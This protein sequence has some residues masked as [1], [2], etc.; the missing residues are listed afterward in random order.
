[1]PSRPDARP[2]QAGSISKERFD[3]PL[4]WDSSH[5]FL[6]YAITTLMMTSLAVFVLTA[7][8]MP[9]QPARVV[10]GL[11]MALM[12]ATALFLLL[13]GKVETSV[14]V[15]VYGTWTL[16]TAILTFTGGLR[17]PLA[18]GYPLITLLSGWLLGARTARSIGFMTLAAIACLTLADTL[19]ILPHP[20]T[21][22][23]I[24][25][26]LHAITNGFAI[27]LIFYLLR[28][29]QNR[30]ADA[31]KLSSDLGRLA[32]KVQAH[33]LDLNRA[34][35][36]AHVGS[37]VYEIATDITHSSAEACRIFGIAEGAT[38]SRASYL[39]H[40]H[41]DD[42][43]AIETAW[44]AALAGEPL[45]QEHRIKTGDGMRWIR[46]R[47]ELER[48]PDGTPLRFVGTT[49]DTTDVRKIESELR[50]AA[51]AFESQ[52]GMIV[53]NHEN[54]I[55]RVNQAF[56][57]I[58]GYSREDAVGRHHRPRRSG[59]HDNAFYAAIAE[60]VKQTGQ[61]TGEIWD[62]RKNG[63]VY[64]AWLTITTVKTS[65][66]GAL[67]GDAGVSHHVITHTDI[68]ERKVAEEEIRNL[69]F[70]DPLTQLPNRR[71]LL[72]RLPQALAARA[73]SGNEGALMFIDLDNFKM[74]NDTLGHDIGDIL[75]QQVAERLTECVRESDT[76]AR[77][78]GDE[79]VIMLTDVDKNLHDAAAK[80][81]AIG[82]KVLASLNQP[83]MLGGHD[84]QSTPS[85][86]VTLFGDHRADMDE[87]FKRA[88]LAMYQAK[89][90]GRNT[91]RFFDPD[92]QA[93]VTARAMLEADLRDGLWKKQFLL[94]YQSQVDSTGHITG[95]EVLVRWQHPVHGMIAPI[96]F[97]PL[98]EETGLILPLGHLLLETACYQ[99]VAWAKRPELAHLQLSVNVSPR[100]FRHRDFVDLTLAIL[101]YTGANPH[102]LKLELTESILVDDVEE[103][104]VKMT[105][106]KDRGVSFSLDDFG[107]GYSSLAYLK[108]L[109]LDQLKIDQSFVRDLLTD[110]N[111][112]AIAKTIVALAESL[113]LSVIAEGVETEE[114]RSCLAQQGC[115]AY[116]GYLFSKPLPV[117]QFEQRVIAATT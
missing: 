46:Q 80:V 22:P 69:A 73:R 100:Q 7:I 56:S 29:Y 19:G 113:G 9:D 17:A 14:L 41:P 72:D 11:V 106:L 68:T 35:A 66:E 60:Q 115:F 83:Y 86:G 32:A 71:L 67:R 93:V 76:V 109:P 45:D 58:T 97:I 104:V 53:T 55:L 44:Q 31:R 114:Q 82:T 5:T 103:L 88:D 37:W 13:R 92:M 108:R 117:E 110:P 112:A 91:I 4:F 26:A 75:L 1:M 15:L 94:Y 63:D 23:L 43:S 81:E 59:R 54:T 70:Y 51:T 102:R 90:A 65:V 33:E 12:A 57:D 25:G 49:Q 18:I 27:V 74:L 116:Q 98:A 34:Q 8:I 3:S 6:K 2:N 64:P 62:K 40:V 79:F 42:R 107:T 61:W 89:A 10:S 47:A 85:I 36:V 38:G 78:G 39:A 84:H 16:V 24:Y 28:N 30:L 95:A 96:R 20:P 99:L 48:G 52:V 21:A 50:I 105:V 111:D 101:Q 77:L 87:L